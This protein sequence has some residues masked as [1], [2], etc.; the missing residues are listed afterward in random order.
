ME[1]LPEESGVGW[2]QLPSC[3]RPL[4]LGMPSPQGFAMQWG[5][6]QNEWGWRIQTQLWP[7]PRPLVLGMPQFWLSVVVFFFFFPILRQ[8]WVIGVPNNWILC[9]KSAS[10]IVIQRGMKLKS[11]G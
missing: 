5:H 1:P 2:N 4:T 8:K 11:E 6:S 7:C 9:I 3:L 10:V